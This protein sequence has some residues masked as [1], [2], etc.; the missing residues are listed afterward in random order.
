MYNIAKCWLIIV[1]LLPLGVSAE[2]YQWRDAA[3]KLHFADKKPAHNRY[4]DISQSVTR[5]NIDSSH[6]LRQGMSDIFTP[7]GSV[8]KQWQKEQQRQLVA[9]VQQE[10][11]EQRKV[12]SLLQGPVRISDA[13][14]DVL[15][16]T[17]RQRQERELRQK[18]KLQRLGCV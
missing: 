14:G 13:K 15:K 1:L 16:V 11:S 7:M 5:V 6:V 4:Q 3:G 9:Q 10:C 8:E 2:V 17:E 12:L 18:S